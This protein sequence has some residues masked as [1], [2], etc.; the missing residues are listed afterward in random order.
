[1]AELV[2]AGDLKSLAPRG[3]SEFDSR[4]RHQL[5]SVVSGLHTF[6]GPVQAPRISAERRSPI[7]VDKYT[8]I[9]SREV[10][11]AIDSLRVSPVRP[12]EFM[13]VSVTNGS[14]GLRALSSG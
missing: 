14:A 4:S 7:S 2:D 6:A 9:A 5:I 8:L 10:S 1:M 3:A 13:N 11:A 12:K